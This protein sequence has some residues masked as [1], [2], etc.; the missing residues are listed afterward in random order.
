[1]GSGTTACVAIKH[2]RHCW[3]IELSEE[4]IDLNAVPRIEGRLSELG[5]VDAEPQPIKFGG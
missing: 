1:M 2:K 3:G 4:Y 5:Y